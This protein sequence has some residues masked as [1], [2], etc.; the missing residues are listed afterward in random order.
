MATIHEAFQADLEAFPDVAD[1]AKFAQYD[2]FDDQ[3]RQGG[4]GGPHTTTGLEP[5]PNATYL[6]RK[7]DSSSS[8]PY[9]EN[10]PQFQKCRRLSYSGHGSET[11]TSQGPRAGVDYF[12]REVSKEDK[13]V[14][15]ALSALETSRQVAHNIAIGS[16]PGVQCTPLASSNDCYT[17]PSRR[18]ARTALDQS[19]VRASANKGLRHLSQRVC[20]IVKEKGRTTYNEVADELVAELRSGD[21][22]EGCSNFDE[23][24]EENVRRRVYDAINV[25]MSAEMMEKDKKEIIWIGNPKT[26]MDNL[27]RMERERAQVMAR[28]E[29]KQKDLQR[30]VEQ[31]AAMQH[32]VH[33]NQA[34]DAQGHVSEATRI[35]IPF[36]VIQTKATAD[37]SVQMSEDCK[38]VDFDF[39]QPVKIYDETIVMKNIM[40]APARNNINSP[41]MRTSSPLHPM[42]A[43]SANSRQDSNIEHHQPQQIRYGSP[44]MGN[45]HMN[46]HP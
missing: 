8:H 12:K 27:Q 32:L 35:H 21:L 19:T 13:T 10:E 9:N 14:V 11:P 2:C 1:F 5:P 46:A 4:L 28:L 36:L 44:S 45:S 25:L 41:S 24:K 22:N 18:S 31:Y 26:G 16:T 3:G 17:R 29:A 39:N 42:S 7:V 34:L 30:F 40:L 43:N 20:S 37:V 38:E 6:P 23:K 15:A 33:R